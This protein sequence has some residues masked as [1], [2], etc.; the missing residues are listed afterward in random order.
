M[1]IPELKANLYELANLVLYTDNYDETDRWGCV[2]GIGIYGLRIDNHVI[3][4]SYNEE[5]EDD[6]D[7]PEHCEIEACCKIDILF[8]RATEVHANYYDFLP[9]KIHL[10]KPHDLKNQ[11]QD[12]G[13]LLDAY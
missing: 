8:D 9:V 4:F 10:D 13:K 2:L 3:L 12:V 6:A 7:Y 1:D 11:K 5:I